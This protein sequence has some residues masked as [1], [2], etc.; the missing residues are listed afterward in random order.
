MVIENEPPYAINVFRASQDFLN[1]GRTKVR[2]LYE[3]YASCKKSDK[4]P[5]YSSEIKD[6]NLPKGV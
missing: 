5:S 4:W 2:E 3:L 6:L 1:A